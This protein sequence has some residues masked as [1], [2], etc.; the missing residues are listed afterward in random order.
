MIND[1]ENLLE[2]SVGGNVAGLARMGKA[3]EAV[4]Y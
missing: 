2:E 3:L 4:R 1:P